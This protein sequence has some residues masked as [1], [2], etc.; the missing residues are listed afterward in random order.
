M[1]K[2]GRPEIPFD[3]SKLDAILQYKASLEDAAEI[4]GV[5]ASTLAKK[6][7]KQRH[8]NFSEYREKKMAKVRL[9]LVQK[10]IE[11]G[12]QGDRTMLIF[13]LKNLCG[14]ADL[15][16][17]EINQK[18]QQRLIIQMGDNESEGEND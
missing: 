10:A 14:W 8:C 5:E 1:S 18:T 13:C 2:P 15:Y 17:Q 11:M 16:T 7:V 12:K 6:I 4:M 3:W 9:T